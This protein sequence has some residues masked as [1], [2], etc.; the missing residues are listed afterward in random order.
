MTFRLMTAGWLAAA[1]SIA[2]LQ[3]AQADTIITKNG[4]TLIGE[5]KIITPKVVKLQT[6][7]AGT[8]TVRSSQIARLETDATLTS[9]MDDGSMVSGRAVLEEGGYV[10]TDSEQLNIRAPFEQLLAAWPHQDKAPPAARLPDERYWD[11]SVAADLTGRQG[12][13]DAVGTRI[14]AE[15]ILASENDEFKF[16]TSIDKAKVNGRTTA[17]EFIIGTAYT[18]YVHGSWGWFLNTEF[19]RDPFESVDLRSSVSGGVSYRVLKKPGHKL[20]LQAGL[21]YRH[22]F[23][24]NGIEQH[25][26]TMDF[27]LDHLW[28][29]KPLPKINPSLLMTNLLS[30]TPSLKDLD[31]FLLVQDSGVDMP[32]G[33]SDW[34]LRVGVKNQYNSEPVRGREEL[35]TTYYSRLL[36]DFD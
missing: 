32:I 14:N 30:I 5:V 16:Y 21:G 31:N 13:V 18:D 7:Y 23:L 25:T 3:A 12:N 6:Q 9:R 22:E 4:A 34:K 36:L 10:V 27:G 15:A 1:L 33:D 20:E 2:T 11:Y 26:P 28:K 8:I 19:E 24:D 35:D 29:F 17:D